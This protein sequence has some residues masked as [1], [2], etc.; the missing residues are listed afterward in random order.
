LPHTEDYTITLQSP[1]DAPAANYGLVVT[2]VNAAPAPTPVP[3]SAAE[4]VQFPPG[5][6][7]ATLTGYV[8]RYSPA[9]YVL[10]ALRGQR[11][12]VSLFTLYNNNTT[13]TVRDAEG[14]FLGAANQDE[15]WFGTLP[16]TG[17]YYVE[18]QAAPEN[19][20]DHFSLRIEIH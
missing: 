11:M 13:V 17:D 19:L 18:V 5:A 14:N 6:T 9:R 10:R 16:S 1:N 8:D 7:N 4:R 15:A 2:I 20:G 12:D 3:P